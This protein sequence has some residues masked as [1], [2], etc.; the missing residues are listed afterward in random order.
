MINLPRNSIPTDEVLVYTI[1]LYYTSDL[2]NKDPHFS[3]CQC[4]TQYS[5]HLNTVLEFNQNTSILTSDLRKVMRNTKRYLRLSNHDSN[6]SPLYRALRDEI[7][8]K[9]IEEII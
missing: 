9:K 1:M 6:S 5:T 4:I 2:N 8:L 7:L 3:I